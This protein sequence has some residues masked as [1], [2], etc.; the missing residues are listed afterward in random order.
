MLYD[1]VI[2]INSIDDF[3]TT[4]VY[5]PRAGRVKIIGTVLHKP[6]RPGR[7]CSNIAHFYKFFSTFSGLTGKIIIF[8]E[9]AHS[10][11]VEKVKKICLKWNLTPKNSNFSRNSNYDWDSVFGWLLG[12]FLGFHT[13]TVGV[14]HK[15]PEWLLFIFGFSIQIWHLF[16]KKK[17]FGVKLDSTFSDLPL[18]PPPTAKPITSP[19]V[20]F[21]QNHLSTSLLLPE[22]DFTSI[23]MVCMYSWFTAR[24]TLEISVN[25]W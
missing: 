16:W 23:S 13:K 8:L 22:N 1:V 7:K 20:I 6:R 4:L 3:W 18:N 21:G 17:V 5:P 25:L 2:S 10:E 14:A 11:T 19:Q 9:S 24:L 15:V 12:T